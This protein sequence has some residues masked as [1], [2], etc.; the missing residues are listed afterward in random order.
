MQL[1]LWYHYTAVAFTCETHLHF[2]VA[3]HGGQ[4][5]L[6]TTELTLWPVHDGLKYRQADLAVA[7]LLPFVPMSRLT[8]TAAH[9]LEG[10]FYSYAAFGVP[11]DDIN[12]HA[13]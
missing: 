2:T 11:L 6:C 7:C 5:L 9:A 8:P 12:L 1:Q 4:P 13:D 10:Q 3:L